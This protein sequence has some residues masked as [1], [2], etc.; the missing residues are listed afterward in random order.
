MRA[1]GLHSD[2]R[3]VV[4]RRA[5]WTVIGRRCGKLSFE[6][7]DDDDDDDHDHDHDHVHAKM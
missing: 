5:W 7:T 3:R 6:K 2:R 1:H 4:G